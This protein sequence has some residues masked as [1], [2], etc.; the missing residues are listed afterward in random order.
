M[1]HSVLL[2]GAFILPLITMA[3]SSPTI[4]AY[5]ADVKTETIDP[6]S[7]FVVPDIS[8]DPEELY[9][10]L[11]GIIE[12]SEIETYDPAEET[13][14]EKFDDIP[15][16]DPWTNKSWTPS[17]GTLTM[18]GGVYAGPSGK[19]TYYN[20]PMNGVVYLMRSIGYTPEDYPYWIRP[21]GVKMFGKYVMVAANLD[22]R[23]K[24]TLLETSLG[25][26]MVCDTGDFA[27]L[28]Q[29]QI[30]IAVNW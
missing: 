17:D 28:D 6:I 3:G 14:P 22:I 2:S 16:H 19:E 8:N 15:R 29:N 24:G 21:D 11:T 30:D 25:T 10:Y 12:K 20:L 18:L 1:I 27:K 7:H 9:D 5:S 23:P 13:E 26:A 4:Y